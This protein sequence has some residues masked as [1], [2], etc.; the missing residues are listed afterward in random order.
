MNLRQWQTAFL[1][2]IPYSQWNIQIRIQIF[3]PSQKETY[4]KY[5]IGFR[6]EAF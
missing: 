1:L 4:S 2:E 5:F 3:K 6:R